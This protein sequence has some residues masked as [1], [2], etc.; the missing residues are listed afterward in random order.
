MEVQY[1]GQPAV[2]LP[3]QLLAAVLRDA[4]DL[5]LAATSQGRQQQ[6]Q[7]VLACPCFFTE[8]ER[9]ALL[10]AAAVAGLGAPRL[11]HA[12]TAAA[13]TYASFRRQE[14]PPS[15]GCGGRPRRLAVVDVGHSALQVRVGRRLH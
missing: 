12:T 8:S 11:L 3:E 9:R 7:C 6:Q 1:L 15:G 10:A 2:L 13:L 14:L 4:A 5:R